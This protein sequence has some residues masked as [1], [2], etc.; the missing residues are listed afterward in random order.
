MN[1][2]GE[3]YVVRFFWI[4]QSWY[5]L[6]SFSCSEIEVFSCGIPI[7]INNDNR[8]ELVKLIA[9]YRNIVSFALIIKY[10]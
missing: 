5:Q 7:S 6:I 3:S 10:F 8:Y 1:W 9:H 2:Q 4:Y